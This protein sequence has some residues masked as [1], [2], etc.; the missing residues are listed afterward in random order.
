MDGPAGLS[1]ATR[2]ILT[3]GDLAVVPVQENGIDVQSAADAVRQG[4]PLVLMF[5]GGDK[6]PRT[7]TGKTFRAIEPPQKFLLIDK[8][9]S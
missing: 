6:R 8:I 1:E 3:R 9:I 4:P 5:S 2:A 7:V